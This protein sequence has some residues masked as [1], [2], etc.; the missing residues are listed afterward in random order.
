MHNLPHFFY[1]ALLFIAILY[2]LFMFVHIVS[3]LLLKEEKNAI[4]EPGTKVS[5]IIPARNEEKNIGECLNNLLE[6]DYPANLIEILVCDDHS[7]DKTKEEVTRVIGSHSN[8]KYLLL[9]ANLSGKKAAIE[10]GIKISTG[11]LIIQTDAD[12]TFGKK[13]IS[14][15][16]QTYKKTNAAMLCGPVAITNESTFCEKF[17][18]LE[19]CGLSLLSGAGINSGFPLLSNAANIAYTRKAFDAVEGFKD[20]THTPTGDDILLMFKIQKKFKHGIKYV[21]NPDAIVWTGAQPGWKALFSQRIRWASKGLHSGNPANSIVSLLVFLANFLPFMGLAGLLI[22]P[23]FLNF[24]VISAI[25]KALVDFLLLSFA[26][27]F[28][29][30]SKLILYYPVSS[31]IVMAY[32]SF[33]GVASNMTGYNW[34][35]RNY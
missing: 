14:S 28:F 9:N 16:V 3:W 33:V 17:Q 20:I 21:K 4:S 24:V 34:K 1:L 13:W 30:K 11:E 26:A 8:C 7:E 22:Y 27:K 5:V 6:Q 2:A 32:T 29:G 25:I 23:Q 15:L 19:M 35:G 12:C 31:I 18:G 10:A